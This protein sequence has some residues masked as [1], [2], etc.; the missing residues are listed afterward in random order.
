[1]CLKFIHFRFILGSCKELSLNYSG[2]CLTH[3]SPNCSNKNC[4]CDQQ[5]YTNCCSDIADIGCHPPYSFSPIVSPSPT[6]AFGKTKSDDLTIHQS[7]L[8]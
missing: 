7:Q 2:C 5:C 4:Y 6:D 8:L 1:M 3:L